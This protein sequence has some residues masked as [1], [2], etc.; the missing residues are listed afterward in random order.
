MPVQAKRHKRKHQ[1]RQGDQRQQRQLMDER[2]FRIIIERL[3]TRACCLSPSRA[4]HRQHTTQEFRQKKY[5]KLFEDLCF[6]SVHVEPNTRKR[7]N[8][9]LSSDST[10]HIRPHTNTQK[11]RK[12][13]TIGN[14][15]KKNK[16]N[17]IG[18]MSPNWAPVSSTI[19][20]WVVERE[21]VRTYILLCV[22]IEHRKNTTPLP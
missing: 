15:L 17:E 7:R 6:K 16:E 3:K 12:N 9:K 4:T 2:S 22:N 14:R 13:T 18:Q 8:K 20:L 11:K 1:N 21:N 19:V 5:C 10:A